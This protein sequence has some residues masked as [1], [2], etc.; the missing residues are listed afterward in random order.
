MRLA[1]ALDLTVDVHLAGGD[2]PTVMI[3]ASAA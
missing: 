3:A 2:E 1:R